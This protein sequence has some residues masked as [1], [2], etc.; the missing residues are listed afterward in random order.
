LPHQE[1][2]TISRLFYAFQNLRR[3]RQRSGYVAIPQIISRIHIGRIKIKY[4]TINKRECRSRLTKITGGSVLVASQCSIALHAF[5][6]PKSSKNH[7]ARTC[8]PASYVGDCSETKD[9]PTVPAPPCCRH[10]THWRH[11]RMSGSYAAVAEAAAQEKMGAL[12][13]VPTLDSKWLPDLGSNQKP[14]D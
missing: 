7:G 4:R 14:A 9:L 13:G 1:A 5:A 12:A 8:A 10:S 2:V 6:V 11:L 3:V